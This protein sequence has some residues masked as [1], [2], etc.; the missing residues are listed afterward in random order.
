MKC[1]CHTQNYS[2]SDTS[3]RKL[4]AYVEREQ[5]CLP[6]CGV[7]VAGREGCA[8][9]RRMNHTHTASLDHRSC[10]IRIKSCLPGSFG[11]WG[12]GR[13]YNQA[14][15]GEPPS[16]LQDCHTDVTRAS[17]QLFLPDLMISFCQKLLFLPSSAA[18]WL[19][20]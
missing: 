11:R 17:T 10:G 4:S 1:S 9:G 3:E 8:G 20:R 15:F 2:P 19:Q 5:I 18:T 12:I 16:S 7:C 14:C 6:I 13:G